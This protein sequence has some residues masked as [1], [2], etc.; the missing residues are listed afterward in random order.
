MKPIYLITLP[1]NFG[2][3][4][5]PQHIVAVFTDLKEAQQD[6][7]ARTRAANDT[8]PRDLDGHPYHIR[9][10]YTDQTEEEAFEM[11]KAGMIMLTAQDLINELQR[12]GYK[13]EG[14]NGMSFNYFN[15]GNKR[16]YKA[17]S[18]SIIEADTKM[19][20]AHVDARRDDNFKALQALRYNHFAYDKERIWEL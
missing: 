5:N 6:H 19:S 18:I 17:R 20:F 10:P 4:V 15:T 16:K 1:H 3:P 12:L 2:R 14:T 13:I 8:A 9:G 7:T 11:I